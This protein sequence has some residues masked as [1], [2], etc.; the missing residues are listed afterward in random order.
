VAGFGSLAGAVGGGV[1]GGAVV[2][3]LLDTSKFDASEGAA[4]PWLAAGLVSE[5]KAKPKRKKGS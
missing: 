2:R 1:I 3:L 4:G 5:V